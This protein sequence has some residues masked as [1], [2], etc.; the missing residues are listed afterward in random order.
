MI[1]VHHNNQKKRDDDFEKD[2]DDKIQEIREGQNL[3]ENRTFENDS[4]RRNIEGGRYMAYL[5]EH[6]KLGFCWW[7]LLALLI[8]LAVVIVYLVRRHNLKKEQKDLE[9]QLS[10]LYAE[11]S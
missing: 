4:D 2:L 6:T 3:E 9:D 5:L 10:D 1:I 8:L 11:D 7:D